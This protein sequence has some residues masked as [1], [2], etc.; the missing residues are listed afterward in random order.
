MRI[1]VSHK[2]SIN[3]YRLGEIIPLVLL[4]EMPLLWTR[5]GLHWKRRQILYS[6]IQRFIDGL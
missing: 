1:A 4:L 6:G 5:C 2:E 3:N